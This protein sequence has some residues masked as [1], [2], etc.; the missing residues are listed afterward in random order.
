MRIIDEH[1]ARVAER[2]QPASHAPP[3]AMD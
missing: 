1:R 2:N 3:G